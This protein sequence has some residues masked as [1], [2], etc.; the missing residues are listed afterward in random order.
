VRKP[1]PVKYR[2]TWIKLAIMLG[3]VFVLLFAGAWGRWSFLPVALL[4]GY[5]GWRELLNAIQ[6]KYEALSLPVLSLGG[7]LTGIAAG[8]ATEPTGLFAGILCS[9]WGM[10]ILPLL[11]LR[12]PLP[13]HNIFAT[14]FGICFVSL[15]L[16]CLLNLVAINYGAFTFLIIVSMANDGFSEGIGRFIGRTQLCPNISP[17]KTVEGAI[18]GLFSALLLGYALYQILQIMIQIER[19]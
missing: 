6:Q 11:I 12:R 2:Q 18:G 8:L 17:G 4:L 14:S 10:A 5:L 16:A 7:G 15:P 1:D 13:L 9:L 3:L 19:R